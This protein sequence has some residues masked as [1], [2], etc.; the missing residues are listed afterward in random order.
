G[1]TPLNP[2]NNLSDITSG[3]QARTNLGLGSAAIQSASA[4]DPA[5]AA[6]AVAVTPAPPYMQIG[7]NLYLPADHMS[8]ATKPPTSGLSFLPFTPSSPN[9]A[10][11][12]GPNGDLMISDTNAGPFYYGK[13][14]TSSIEA[15]IAIT[16]STGGAFQ[17][18]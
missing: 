5:G 2:A 3:S 14:P 6:S 8:L 15:V 1:F 13:S 7:T 4:F 12:Y 11:T 10:P 16:N 18:G 9:L 17:T